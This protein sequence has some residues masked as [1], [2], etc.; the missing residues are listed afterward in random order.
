MICLT[1]GTHVTPPP[2]KLAPLGHL[3]FGVHLHQKGALRWQGVDRVG[4]EC[5]MSLVSCDNAVR[6]STQV[7]L[8]AGAKG[9]ILSKGSGFS[10]VSLR[11]CLQQV[12][13][14][15]RRVGWT[16]RGR[17]TG[18]TS[19]CGMAGRGSACPPKCLRSC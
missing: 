4:W 8:Y 19:V 15:P 3:G 9:K 11:I 16:R 6:M 5:H 7:Q 12:P 18:P 10:N 13:D 1:T 14:R 2:Q 17:W